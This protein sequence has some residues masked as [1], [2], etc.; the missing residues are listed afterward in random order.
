[1]PCRL[2][3][4]P[5]WAPL[6]PFWTPMLFG[7]PNSS[8]WE[9]IQ[10]WVRKS[11]RS[12]ATSVASAFRR[13][14]QQNG[15]PARCFHGASP[16]RNPRTRRAERFGKKYFVARDSSSAAAERGNGARQ[17]LVQGRGLIRKDRYRDEIP[18]RP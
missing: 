13:L 2:F 9:R 7:T 8:V 10:L 11:D 6:L 3:R 5:S 17:S 14:P 1:M 15:S 16:G 18:A 4:P 12:C